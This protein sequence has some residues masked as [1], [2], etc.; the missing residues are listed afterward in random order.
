MRRSGYFADNSRTNLT[1]GTTTK[2]YGD[3]RIV[4]RGG[5]QAGFAE[6]R[7]DVLVKILVDHA[8]PL[9]I[10]HVGD[11]HFRGNPGGKLNSLLGNTVP[12]VY[13]NDGDGS[14]FVVRRFRGFLTVG[15]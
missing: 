2:R 12:G 11:D 3:G 1:S 14:F 7:F 8:L 15:G 5:V 4:R 10:F 6:G 9:A 13:R